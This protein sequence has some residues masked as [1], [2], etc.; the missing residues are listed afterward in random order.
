MRALNIFAFLAGAALIL[1][2]I[3]SFFQISID[4]GRSSDPAADGSFRSRVGAPIRLA[5]VGDPAASDAMRQA[6]LRYADQGTIDP[7][8][9]PNDPAQADAILYLLNGWADITNAPW[10]DDFQSDYGIVAA[11]DDDSFAI[12]MSDGDRPLNRVYYNLN[13]YRDWGTDCYARLFVH[14]V[15]AGPDEVFRPPET[16]PI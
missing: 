11:N 1:F 13:L 15:S 7:E 3:G 10:Q 8:S 12:S 2:A 9:I 14:E 16:C 5:V 6:I 4:V